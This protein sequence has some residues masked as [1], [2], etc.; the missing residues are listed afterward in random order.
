LCFA[1]GST[2]K[3]GIEKNLFAFSDSNAMMLI[4][5]GV[6]FIPLEVND[7]REINGKARPSKPPFELLA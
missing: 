6:A 1:S 5:A 7:L 2:S 4:L 3:L